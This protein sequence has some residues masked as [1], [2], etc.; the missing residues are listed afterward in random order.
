MATVEGVSAASTACDREVN[1]TMGGRTGGGWVGGVR[2]G[3]SSGLPFGEGRPLGIPF[4]FGDGDCCALP[5][6][7]KDPKDPESRLEKL[8]L[9]LW[10]ED[11]LLETVD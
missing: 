11:D 4:A 8:L 3:I 7:P 2:V 10:V 1:V 5:K 6:A 9:L